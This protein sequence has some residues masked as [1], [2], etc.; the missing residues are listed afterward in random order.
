MI[1][2][3]NPFR[4]ESHKNINNPLTYKFHSWEFILSNYSKIWEVI[5]VSSFSL[6]C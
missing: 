3:K 1:L 5:A 6:E 2:C 4:T